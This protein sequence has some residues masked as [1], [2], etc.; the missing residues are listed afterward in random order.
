M[1][2]TR[3]NVA[4]LIP[5]V[6]LTG[7]LSGCAMFPYNIGWRPDEPKVSEKADCEAY[8]QYAAYA[9]E[10]QEAYHTRSSQNRGWLYVAGILGIGVAAASGGLAA[11][12]AVAAGTLALLAISGGAAG[13]FFATIN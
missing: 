8:K 3:R 6:F 11:A 2:S 12:S 9:Q 13:G 5:V 1:A 4:R 10:L 7:I